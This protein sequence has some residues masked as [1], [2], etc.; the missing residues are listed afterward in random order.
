ML[1][2]ITLMKLTKIF[3]L[4]YGAIVL[5]IV[6]GYILVKY[7]IIGYMPSLQ[8]LQNPIDH[9][10]SQVISADG[11]QLGTYSINENRVFAPHDSISPYVFKALVATEDNRF[12]DHSGIDGRGLLRAIVKRGLL[13]QHSAGGGS[14]VTQQL[15]KQLYSATARNTIQRLFQK[16]VEWVIAIEIEKI[17]TKE[18]ILTLYLNYFDF[19]Y[20]AVGI[21]SAAKI[22]F[23]K[24]PHELTLA[25]SAMLVGMCNN[26][27]YYNP[28]RS[29]E[30]TK[31]RR[32]LVLDRMVKKGYI[33]EAEAASAK[34][35]E[36]ALNFH[37]TDH[38]NGLATYLREYLRRIMMARKPERAD[39]NQWQDQEF[40]QDSIAW[41]TNPIYGW[42]NKNRK[43]DGSSY[44]LYTDGLRIY[45][46]IDSRMQQYAEEAVQKHVGKYLQTEFNRQKS[47]SSRFPYTT[48]LSEKQIDQILWRAAKQSDRY[49]ALKADGLS[50]SDIRKE[51]AKPVSMSVFSY[52]GER[53]T[54]MSPMDSIRYYKSFLR[55]GMMAIEP[56][57]GYVK[58]YV[59]GIDFSHFQYDMVSVGRR[60]IGSTMK[61]FV[62]AMAMED[63]MTPES[64][65]LNAPVNYGG[66]TPR[67]GSKARMGETVSL[68]WGLAQSNNWVTAN[69][70][71]HVDPTGYRLVDFLHRVGV[72][73]RELY[74]S[75]ALC[76]GTCD[77][78]V[79]E[80]AGG[81]TMFVNKGLRTTPL[82]VS[83]IED[84]AGNLLAEFLPIFTETISENSSYEM[85]SMLKGVVEGGTGGRLRHRYNVPGDLAGKT[86][87]TNNNSDGWFVGITPRLI[88]ATWVGGEDR[89]IHFNNTAMG[90]GA[91]MA[92]PVFAYFMNSVYADKSL[93]YSPT[94]KFDFPVVARD[95]IGGAGYIEGEVAEGGDGAGDSGGGYSGD[96]ES[97]FD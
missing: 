32:N 21:K 35:E 39:Y 56:Q 92:L 23:N 8:E 52:R 88:A 40:Y 34:S 26:P 25:E 84:S 93:G 57:T 79:S 82:V 41:E 4:A 76:L 24:S 85:L 10:A 15:A 62:Y 61:P 54:I 87:T 58:A 44:N 37:R 7:G 96:A 72:A 38:R 28:V 48:N 73:E 36:L 29:P 17:Y 18:E 20:S 63:G 69:L 50:E 83:R 5:L 81:Y 65:M 70:M 22:Y 46:T 86:G 97:L 59:G 2:K 43:A 13:G 31:E 49:R 1:R 27:S 64:G 33:T 45:S 77:I 60:Q 11:K 66:W 9:Y 71:A 89:D 78:T 75:L 42:C 91:T 12:Y 67:N 14:T 16:P 68:R 94:D 19:L 6:L 95:S 74:P 53:D 55:A 90:Q 30:R 51:F 47:G 80:L 3:W